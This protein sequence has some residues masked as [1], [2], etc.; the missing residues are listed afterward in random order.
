M[1]SQLKKFPAYFPRP[2]TAWGT[3]RGLAHILGEFPGVYAIGRAGGAFVE[4]TQKSA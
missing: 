1:D 3:G 4:T 2:Y